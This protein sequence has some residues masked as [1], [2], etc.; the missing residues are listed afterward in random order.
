MEILLLI[1]LF[2]L[3]VQAAEDDLEVAVV[4]LQSDTTE[5]EALSE[6]RY[7]NVTMPYVCLITD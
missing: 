2:S 4:P 1:Y 5:F 3:L 6:E 7:V